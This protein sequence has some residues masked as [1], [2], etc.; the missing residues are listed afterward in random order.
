[1][2]RAR[3]GAISTLHSLP[4][5]VA[6]CFVGAPLDKWSESPYPPYL[7]CPVTLPDSNGCGRTWSRYCRDCY[8]HSARRRQLSSL[9]CQYPQDRTVSFSEQ[10]LRGASPAEALRWGR[11]RVQHSGFMMRRHRTVIITVTEFGWNEFLRAQ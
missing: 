2:I 9:Q 1:M 3:P 7:T 10:R 6:A 11:F 5:L 4:L 8:L